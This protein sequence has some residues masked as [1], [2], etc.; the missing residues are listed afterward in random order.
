MES[1]Q[2]KNYYQF[3]LKELNSF[4]VKIEPLL[5]FAR[6]YN[7]NITSMLQSFLGAAK[8]F[9]DGTDTHYVTSNPA[10]LND[11]TTLIKNFKSS[12]LVFPAFLEYG[13]MKSRISDYKKE[14]GFGDTEI[15]SFYAVLDDTFITYQEY[16]QTS[17]DRKKAVIFGQSVIKLEEYFRSLKVSYENTIN[18][19]SS[20]N[21]AK[22]NKPQPSAS[23]VPAMRI[24]AESTVKSENK[25][26]VQPAV[27]QV[28]KPDEVRTA[29]VATASAPE[30]HNKPVENKP[31][32]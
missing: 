32:P 21:T 7:E 8:I 10:I 2:I 18:L 4:E 31:Q 30:H 5:Q 24:L 26:A 6:D 19:L 1:Q 29:P 27:A 16:L 15:E 17:D 22:F 13:S 11:F 25:P 14:N 28:K 20:I 12:F 9:R 3:V 23:P